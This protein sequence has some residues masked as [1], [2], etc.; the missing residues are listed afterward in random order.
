MDLEHTWPEVAAQAFALELCGST[1]EAPLPSSIFPT[2]LAYL[3]V[4]VALET[5]MSHTVCVCMYLY[6]KQLNRQ[7]VIATSYWSGSGLSGF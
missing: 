5:A 7:I 2:S 4:L 6:H 1:V 3:F